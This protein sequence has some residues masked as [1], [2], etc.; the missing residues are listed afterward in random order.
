MLDFDLFLDIVIIGECVSQWVAE[1]RVDDEDFRGSSNFD[2]AWGPH[3]PYILVCRSRIWPFYTCIMR[4]VRLESRIQHMC[5]F[6]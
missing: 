4:P 5:D 1:L 2:S 3:P 6:V